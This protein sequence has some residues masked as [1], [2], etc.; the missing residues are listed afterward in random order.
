V[1]VTADATPVVLTDSGARLTF[2]GFASA[3]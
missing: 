3:H 2:I 1:G